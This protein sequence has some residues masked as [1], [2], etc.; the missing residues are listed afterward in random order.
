MG[1]WNRTI[2]L[3]LLTS[4]PPFYVRLLKCYLIYQSKKMGKDM[5]QQ[6]YIIK[7]TDVSLAE[8]NRYA[9]ELRDTILD[10]APDIQV[11]R[12]REDNRTQDFGATLVLILGTSSVTVLAKAIG[13]WL[14]L[15]NSA[16]LKVET[17]EGHILVKNITS[18]EA[19]K[20][21]ELLVSKE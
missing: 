9:S 16:S 7:F 14:K 18:K 10:S 4:E 19:A 6:V 15:R 13:D 2:V 17:P 3:S 12:R 5:N 11:E 21:A 20:L 8:A 1:Y